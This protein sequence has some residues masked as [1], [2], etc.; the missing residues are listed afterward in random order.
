MRYVALL[1]L[2]L[3]VSPILLGEVCWRVPGPF[4]HAIG[5]SLA[6]LGVFFVAPIGF[7]LLLVGSFGLLSPRE[8]KPSN[9]NT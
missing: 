4:C 9:D 5:G 2:V 6:L 1:G 8:K 3:L 7:A